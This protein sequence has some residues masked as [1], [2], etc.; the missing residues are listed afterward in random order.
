MGRERN[1]IGNK[2]FR[3]E[4]NT[5][6]CTAQ[7]CEYKYKPKSGSDVH[8]TPPVGHLKRKHSILYS[9]AVEEEKKTKPKAKNITSYVES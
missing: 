3:Y 7:G 6:T 9:E 8:A 4:V 2:H 1:F 5:S